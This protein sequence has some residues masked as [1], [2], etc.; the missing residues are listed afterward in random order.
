MEIDRKKFREQVVAAISNIILNEI[1]Y[2]SNIKNKIANNTLIGM[3]EWYTSGLVAYVSRD[4]DSDADNLNKIYS[5]SKKYNKINQLTGTDAETIG[6]AIWNYVAK[7][8]GPQVISNIVYLTRITKSVDN[9][10]MYV[11][12]V[13]LR[14]L[15]DNLTEYYKTQYDDFNATAEEPQGDDVLKR[16][17]KNVTY[18]QAQYNSNTDMMAWTENK[19]GKYWIKTYDFGSGKQKTIFRREH[20]LDQIIDNTY[21]IVRWHPSGKM[22]GFMI[23]K[24]GE[25]Y[26]TTY[27]LESKKIK[28]IQMPSMEK[29]NSFD[30]SNDGQNLVIAGFN[31]GQSDIFVFNIA[32]NTIENITNDEAD[33]YDPLYVNKSKQIVGLMTTRNCEEVWEKCLKIIQDNLA[34]VAFNTWFAPIVPVDL[35]GS[36]LT[37]Q[38]PSTY[39]YEYLEEHYLE[40]MAMT[41]HRVIGPDANLEYRIVVSNDQNAGRTVT[42]AMPSNHVP[43]RIPNVSTLPRKGADEPLNPFAIP[44]LKKIQIDPH[45]NPEYTFENYVE[46][47]CNRLARAAGFA[48]AG[49]PAG[50]SFNPLFI[51][52]GSGLGKTHLANAIGLEVKK[53]FPDKVVLYVDANKFLT[54]YM[55]ATRDNNRN[56]FINFYQMI[57]VLIL[58]DVQYFADKQGTQEVFF[59]IFNY[60]HQAS[61]ILRICLLLRLLLVLWQVGIVINNYF[62]L[63]IAKELRLECYISALIVASEFTFFHAVAVV[64]FGLQSSKI[65]KILPFAIWLVVLIVLDLYNAAIGIAICKFSIALAHVVCAANHFNATNIVIFI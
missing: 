33:D 64:C 14:T 59:Q 23:E 52:G 60:L 6:F 46:G 16:N 37:I 27:Q 30:Y 53:N 10:F 56:D 15:Q 43:K 55:Q 9:A 38:V 32:G 58:D 36:Q 26:Y 45:L 31:N 5:L 51:Y 12:G 2:G 18:A 22:L 8:Y 47:E 34:K 41:L 44:G 29:I 48:V 11:L 28:E 65:V 50:T 61:R 54:Q 24:K 39:F 7:I 1:I 25:I 57:D 49:N 4:W 20:K 17:R 62:N 63:T 19:F 21:P 13:N 40:L 42:V 35:K 3:P